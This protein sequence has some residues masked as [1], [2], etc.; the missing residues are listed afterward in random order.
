MTVDSEVRGYADKAREDMDKPAT[1]GDI[2]A[3]VAGLDR[4]LKAVETNQARLTRALVAGM[5]AVANELKAMT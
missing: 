3:I 2:Q 5:E 1:K 4:R